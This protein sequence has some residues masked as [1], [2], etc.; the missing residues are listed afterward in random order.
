[1]PDVGQQIRPLPHRGVPAEREPD[2]DLSEAVCR[3]ARWTDELPGA[4]LDLAASR[5]RM[6]AAS[7]S[8][9][10]RTG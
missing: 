5:S 7:A 2:G 4:G 6:Y 3:V 8:S 9:T 1:M 10:R